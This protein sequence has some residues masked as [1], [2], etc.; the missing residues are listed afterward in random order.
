MKKSLAALA[1]LG[2]FA[3]SAFAADVTL[4]GL[5]DYG[6]NYTHKDADTTGVDANDQFEMRAGQNS[7]SRFGLR[8]TEDLGNGLKVG[9]VLEN[10]F[11]ADS[12]ALTTSGK[13]FDRESQAY[14][15]GAFGKVGFG[16]VG[17]LASANGTYGLLGRFSPFSSGWGDTI[18]QRTVMANGYSRMDNMVSYV[19]PDF[20]GF[21]VYAQYSFKNA[22][23]GAGDEN[24]TT[25][26]RYYGIGA[27]FDA[28]NFAAVAIVDSI[29]MAHPGTYAN[30]EELDDPM[31]V[32]LG[33]TY[34]FGVAKLFAS[35]Q[36]F[37]NV[38]EVGYKNSFAGFKDADGNAFGYGTQT[39]ADKKVYGANM[40][41][42]GI[43]IGASAP[44]LGGTLAG[45]IGYMDADN[46]GGN[47]KAPYES[48]FDVKRWNVAV[49]YSYNLSKR[50]S[51]YAGAAYTKDSVKIMNATGT[52]EVA[53]QDPTSVEVLG[54]MI[55]RF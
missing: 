52:Q 50:T 51:L 1:V 6:F 34:D 18:G 55:H 19:T 38:R 32:T 5:V 16:R 13:I 49:G 21:K 46:D 28:G 48:G 22:A 41:G 10:G 14:L 35:G 44:V 42:Y 4:Y 29:N 40:T 9:F 11:A 31:T 37:D 54:G 47:D 30:E 53:N 17:Q 36:Y 25:A 23:A 45:L 2:A 15:E 12:G 39:N 7:G 26:D 24:K 43:A 27:T 8:G 33:A 20:V 3:G